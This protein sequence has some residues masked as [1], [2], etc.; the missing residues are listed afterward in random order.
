MN[1]RLQNID[2]GDRPPNRAMTLIELIGV[3]AIIGI[4]A[5]ALIPVALRILDRIAAQREVAT[6]RTF[7]NV[8]EGSIL[9]HRTIPNVAGLAGAVAAE[10]G[11][12]VAS[13]T[14]NPRRRQ[15][16]LLMDGGGWLGT[17]TLPYAQGAAG[18][19]DLPVN[20]RVMIV[21]SLGAPLPI[22]SGT[23]T[24]ADFAALWN[25]PD[26]TVPA[27]W[28]ST[29]NGNP[30]D[31][32]IQ[33]INL[34]PL[35]VNL[36]LSTYTSSLQGQYKIR[37]T[38]NTFYSAPTGTGTNAYYLRGT[39]LDLYSGPAT[40][41]VLNHSAML[42]RDISYV[43]ED[44]IWKNSIVGG[45]TYGLGDISGIVAAFLAA[46]NNTRAVLP[47]PTYSNAQQVVIVDSFIQYMSNYQVWS[48]NDF[49]KTTVNPLV[50]DLTKMVDVQKN[51]M[52]N[53]WGLFLKGSAGNDHYPSNAFPCTTP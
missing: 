7:A 19:A 35:F 31:V 37:D 48:A 41:A 5:G 38:D 15:R 47:Y 14:E 49:P 11:V 27:S 17:A 16:A 34:S 2:E 3:L 46:T 13:V 30:D 28:N 26:G 18:L 43:F 22:T 33:R 53:V 24:A 10:A 9:R 6:L 40:N 23:A 25:A 32:K 12:D 44:G 20:A 29:W 51:M 4:L 36:V 45:A 8:L 21:S 50:P 1:L 42:D 52:S 39:V